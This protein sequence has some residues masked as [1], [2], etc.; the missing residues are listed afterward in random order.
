MIVFILPVLNPTIASIE[1]FVNEH[2]WIGELGHKLIIK[3]SDS[4]SVGLTSILK[5]KCDFC[6]VLSMSDSSIYEAWNQSLNLLLMNREFEST[7]AVSFIGLNDRLDSDFY[8]SAEKEIKQ[9]AKLVYG[10]VV[11]DNSFRLLDPENASEWLFDK[12]T[13]ALMFPHPGSL[14][15]V[16]LFKS[17]HF[18]IKFR[19]AGDLDFYLHHICQGSISKKDVIF[20]NKRQARLGIGGVS[21]SFSSLGIYVREWMIIEQRYLI[22]LRKDVVRNSFKMILAN[23]GVFNL[24]RSIYYLG[25]KFFLKRG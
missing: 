19:L 25:K 7:C 11:D 10:Y 22:K 1:S 18:D 24:F 2:M 16:S 8:I 4:D 17:F 5:A 14:N 3:I 12:K 23:F 13:V 6:Y 15:A 9:G 21:N 20:V